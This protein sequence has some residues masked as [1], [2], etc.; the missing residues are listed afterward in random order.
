MK[1]K[2]NKLVKII[3]SEIKKPHMEDNQISRAFALSLGFI[4]IVILLAFAA[5]ALCKR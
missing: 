3:K 4:S 2:T 1:N 5:F